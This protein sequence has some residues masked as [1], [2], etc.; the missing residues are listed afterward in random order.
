MDLMLAAAIG[1]GAIVAFGGG[2]TFWRFIRGAKKSSK[3]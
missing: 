3:E 1:I 2:A